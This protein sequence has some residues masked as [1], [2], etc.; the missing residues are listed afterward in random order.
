M[1]T[2]FFLIFSREKRNLNTWKT[3]SSTAKAANSSRRYLLTEYSRQRDFFFVSHIH[4]HN[5]ALF[6]ASSTL[7]RSHKRVTISSHNYWKKKKTE[8]I[9]KQK[10]KHAHEII[11]QVSGMNFTF[12]IINTAPH[13][14]LQPVLL[15]HRWTARARSHKAQRG[16]YLFAHVIAMHTQTGNSSGECPNQFR[17][18]CPRCFDRSG[19]SSKMKNSLSLAGS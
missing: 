14:T 4:K 15:L 18:G 16:R 7:L 1:C 8:I 19:P 6:V 13:N 12:T 9:T 3:K 17:W 10:E 5:L 11:T 2:P